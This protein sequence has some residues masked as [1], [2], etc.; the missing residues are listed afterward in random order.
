M[1]EEE[2]SIKVKLDELIPV[3]AKA[4]VGDF[5]TNLPV[6]DSDDELAQTYTGIQI[7]IDVI[8]NKIADLEAEI[9]YRKRIEVDIAQREERFQTTLDTMVE[10]FQIID[11]NFRYI[12]VN[13]A[14]A[15]QARR[16][17]KELLG[18]T[19]MEMY[20]DIEKTEMFIYLKRCMKDRVAHRM[21]NE[22]VYPDGSRNWFELRIEPVQE[23][24]L[25]LSLD[26]N[27]RKKIEAEI[28]REKAE[29]EAL[30]SSIGDGMIATGRDGKIVLVNKIFES[31][32]GWKAHEIVGK[33][34]GDVIVLQKENGTEVASKDHPLNLAL[35]SGKRVTS[36]YYLFRKDHTKFP[37]I[38]IATPIMLGK[39]IIGAVKIL[40]D[41]TR[42]KELDQAKDE[43]ISMASHELRTPMTAIKGLT[44]MIL[45]GDYG[46]IN[47][48]LKRPLENIS[49]SSNRQIRLIN[50]LLNISRLQTGNMHY[51]LTNFAI[52]QVVNEVIES[53]YP[54][55]KD[56][57]VVFHLGHIDDVQVQGD[58]DWVK[59][60]L[61]NL[62]GNALK[63]TD[64]GSITI[65]TRSDKDFEFIVVI[66]TGAGIEPEDQERLF[67]RFRQV[68]TINSKKAIG[69]GLGLYI[70]RKVARK[71]GGDIK[72]EKSVK[73]EGSTFVFSLPKANTTYAKKVKDEVIKEME[74]ASNKKRE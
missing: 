21:E 69:S 28:A 67:E 43:F 30:L 9:A 71:M 8:R 65:S 48:E 45:H 72:L 64:K 19:M 39:E 4:S 15:L 57:G 68:G 17:K 2:K 10:G 50:D 38:V 70:S 62:L 23:G 66:D 25:I 40:H 14:V 16:S 36:M 74:I 32:V 63:F 60:I 44:S 41:I 61:N 11:F 13:N 18:H 46:P 53:L 49:I 59:Q 52:K 27:E 6:L 31:L 3:F 54:I 1:S 56:R 7:M 55:T 47:E 51:N 37:A 22:F 58:I 42:E 20:P 35:S 5:S 33:T 24:V 26:I 12:F 29:D 73:G 34:A